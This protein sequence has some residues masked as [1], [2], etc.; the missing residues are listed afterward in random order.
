MPNRI[1]VYFAAICVS[2]AC[3][4]AGAAADRHQDSRISPDHPPS[5]ILLAQSSSD[6]GASQETRRKADLTFWQSVKD[7][8]DPAELQTYIDAFPDGTFVS[9]A[10]LRIKKLGGV[11]AAAE[12]PA[13]DTPR[14]SEAPEGDPPSGGNAAA[15]DALAEAERLLGLSRD[16]IDNLRVIAEVDFRITAPGE[17]SH[18][19]LREALELFN[20]SIEDPSGRYWSHK[21]RL[22]IKSRADAIRKEKVASGQDLIGMLHAVR[23]LAETGFLP[24]SRTVEYGGKT[25]EQQYYHVRVAMRLAYDRLQSLDLLEAEYQPEFLEAMLAYQ[26]TKNREH[27]RGYPDP[28]SMRELAVVEIARQYM[29]NEAR[30]SFRMMTEEF[31]GTYWTFGDHTPDEGLDPKLRCTIYV[32]VETPYDSKTVYEPVIVVQP[33]KPPTNRTDIAMVQ[34]SLTFSVGFATGILMYKAMERGLITQEEILEYSSLEAEHLQDPEDQF[35]ALQSPTMKV[36]LTVD[37]DV[38]YYGDYI[39]MISEGSKVSAAFRKGN[40][41]EL[42]YFSPYTGRIETFTFELKGFTRAYQFARSARCP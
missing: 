39:S 22:A 5:L 7:S 16:D 6:T 19:E 13:G 33:R 9:L 1:V 4:S 40:E 36:K 38:I 32:E 3:V 27:W 17:K 31:N 10:K 35:W 28:A 14:Q 8:S 12:M 23:A 21:S 11:P 41:G 20:A 18:E 2:F 15:D 37:G 26:K 24:K 25:Y 34:A 42:K 30:K 29:L